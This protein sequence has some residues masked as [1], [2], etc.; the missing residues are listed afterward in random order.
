MFDLTERERRA[1]LHAELLD[2]V[3]RYG[4]QQIVAGPPLERLI[5]DLTDRVDV[6]GRNGLTL[7][8][9]WPPAIGMVFRRGDVQAPVHRRA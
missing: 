4:G 5:G 7:A 9:Q 8:R 3:A 2:V 1:T 6:A